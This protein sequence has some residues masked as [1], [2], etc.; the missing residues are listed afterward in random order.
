MIPTTKP[1]NAF[2]GDTTRILTQPAIDNLGRAWK[3]GET[4]TPLCGGYDNARR[5]R[6]VEFGSPPARFE[7]RET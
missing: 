2:P 5:C 6:Y 3:R 1:R 4:F 7:D